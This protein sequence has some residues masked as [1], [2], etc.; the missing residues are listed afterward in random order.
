MDALKIVTSMRYIFFFK[1]Y[2]FFCLYLFRKLMKK[3]SPGVIT[4]E[5][6][7]YSIMKLQQLTLQ[8]ELVLGWSWWTLSSRMKQILTL[9]QCHFNMLE[10]CLHLKSKIQL[11]SWKGK[12]LLYKTE[13]N[14]DYIRGVRTVATIRY[15]L[16]LLLNKET[17]PCI[18]VPEDEKVEFDDCQQEHIAEQV[19]RSS[20]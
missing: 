19:N 17:F 1:S 6:H 14:I 3:E 10:E 8:L 20:G 9:L 11:L 7:M 2:I 13:S 12:K 5:G 16:I 4:E 15:S 18:G